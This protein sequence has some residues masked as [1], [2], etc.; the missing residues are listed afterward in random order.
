MNKQ[1][2]TVMKKPKPKYHDVLVPITIAMIAPIHANG[3]EPHFTKRAARIAFLI[4]GRSA[5][6]GRMGRMMVR[7]NIVY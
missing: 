7:P 3:T 4:L 6:S 2:Q 5:G 1:L